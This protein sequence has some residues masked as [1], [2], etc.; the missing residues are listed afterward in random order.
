MLRSI[1]DSIPL[2][3]AE[4][5]DAVNTPLADLS[6]MGKFLRYGMVGGASA[7]VDFSIYAGF[8]ALGLHYLVAAT[9]SFV[10]A[11][12]FNYALSI[13]F[14]FQSG[15]HPKHREIVLIYLVSGIGI[16]INLAILALSVEWLGLDPLIGKVVGTGAVFG[17][18]FSARYFWIFAR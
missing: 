5:R 3:R 16:V 10:L 18:N 7:V 4:L 13:R 2:S 8:L 15:Y 11:V 14:V 17:W 9:L 12:G 1:R 6:P